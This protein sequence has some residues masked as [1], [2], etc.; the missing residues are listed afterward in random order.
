MTK[1][2]TPSTILVTG[3]NVGLGFEAARQLALKDS[4]KKVIL[5]KTCNMKKSAL[6]FI[7]PQSQS[8]FLTFVLII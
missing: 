1:F 2:I 4:T 7:N 3:A 8:N 6:F 5:G